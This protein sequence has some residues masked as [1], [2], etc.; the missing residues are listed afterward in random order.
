MTNRKICNMLRA[1]LYNNGFEYGFV[2]NGQKYKP[3][4]N[5]GFDVTE[6][7]V[8]GQQPEFLLNKLE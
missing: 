8:I 7:I 3:N 5:D 4:M 6:S 1:E 2:L